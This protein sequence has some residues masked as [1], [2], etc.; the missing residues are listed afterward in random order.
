M[1]DTYPLHEEWIEGAIET[2]SADNA[3]ARLTHGNQVQALA[4]ER[5][6]LH[7]RVSGPFENYYVAAYARATGDWGSNFVG[8]YKICQAKPGSYWDADAMLAGCCKHSESTGFGALEQAEALAALQ[9]ARLRG[10]A[11]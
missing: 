2:L 1:E 6:E 5:G 8:E 7:A 4:V 11:A 3:R 9:I 10:L